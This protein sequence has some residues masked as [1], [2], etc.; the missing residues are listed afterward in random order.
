MNKRQ[1]LEIALKVKGI[2]PA[3]NKSG[4]TLGLLLDIISKDEYS[5]ILEIQTITGCS[6][7]T[8]TRFLKGTFPERDPIKDKKIDKYI[9]SLIGLKQCSSCS[10]ILKFSEFNK[11]KSKSDGL[12]SFCYLCSGQSRVDSYNKDPSKE[13]LK[14]SIRK[15]KLVVPPW[16]SLEELELFYKNRPLGH[17]V[18]HIIPVTHDLVCGLHCVSN[19]QY[20]LEY[21][22]L[23]KSNTFKPHDAAGVADGPSNR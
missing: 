14:N 1:Y 21:D 12:Q 15:R 6:K 5:L 2:E 23:S 19:L 20:L 7:E 4:L 13:I 8:I 22:N 17:H 18:D 11:N 10:G 3:R 9:L 16:Q